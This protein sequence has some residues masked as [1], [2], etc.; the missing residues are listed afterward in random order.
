MTTTQRPDIG[1]S[2]THAN[3]H[4]ARQ[5]FDGLSELLKVLSVSDVLRVMSRLKKRRRAVAYRLLEKD[6]AL[7]VFERLSPSLQWELLESLQTDEVV[8]LFDNLEPDDRVRLVD[9][10][11]A[12]VAARL[13]RGLS[14]EK[15]EQTAALLGY[16]EGSIGRHMSPQ[17]VTTRADL[18]VTETLDR[19]R[20]RLASAETVYYI[21]VTDS[22]R[23]IIGEVTLRGLIGVGPETLIRELMRETHVAHVAEDAERVARRMAKLG[24]SDLSIVDDEHRLVGIFTLDDAVR[25]L[26]H[27][28]NV[29]AARHGG[30]E[31]LRRPYLSTP[32]RSV[33]R[34]RIVWLLVLAA[35]ATF[36]VQVLSVFEA[37]LTE[38]TVLALFVPL[39]IG[40]GGNTGNQAATT[41]TRA[42]ALHDVTP[43]DA[44]LVLLRELRVGVL[45]GLLLGVLGFGIAALV[46]SV[47]VGAVIGLT[48]VAVC[49]VAASVGGV[50]PLIARRVKVDPA[51]FSNPF[52][53]T[54]VD[55]TGLIIYFLIARAVFQV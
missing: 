50:M 19:L 18:S 22:E 24:A 48:L 31:P 4:L 55:A 54:F 42:L 14:S 25:I 36:T 20:R 52:I 12:T 47:E 41:V 23:R 17:F 33:V 10:L 28:E 3:R 44:L 51:V 30:S 34:S 38:V 13:L 40:T 35:G 5:D 53:S 43:R 39:I 32:I 49:A 7:K 29:D 21:P 37:T 27:E 2:V 1:R 8:S 46:F 26:E 45:L 6:R 9:E 16:P 11:P 15:Q